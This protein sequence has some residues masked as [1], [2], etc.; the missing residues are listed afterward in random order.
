MSLVSNELF[1]SC[2]RDAEVLNNYVL[3][4]YSHIQVKGCHR[5]TTT[6]SVITRT[7]QVR[8]GFRVDTDGDGDPS[9]QRQ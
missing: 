6:A 7:K 1:Q 4:L 5:P 2:L 3:V 9:T 8:V